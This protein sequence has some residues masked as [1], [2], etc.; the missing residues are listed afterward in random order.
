MLLQSHLGEIHLL[1]ALPEAWP[2]GSVQGLCARGG[3]AVDMSWQD[4][5]LV[6]ATIHSRNGDVCTVRYGDKTRQ[7]RLKKGQSIELASMTPFVLPR[8]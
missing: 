2:T 4:G 6:S 1:P 8:N 3:F 7:L 5:K